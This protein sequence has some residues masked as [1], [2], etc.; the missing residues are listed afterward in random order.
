MSLSFFEALV[1]S[2]IVGIFLGMLLGVKFLVKM[3]RRQKTVLQK[4]FKL[5]ELIIGAEKKILAR[6]KKR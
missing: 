1:L 4:I 6:L 5:E 2:V 3:E